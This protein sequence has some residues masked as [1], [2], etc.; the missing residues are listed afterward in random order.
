M[1]GKVY[2]IGAGPGD[3]ELLTRKAARI[4]AAAEVVLHDALVAQEILSLIAAGAEVRNVGKRCGRKSI[5]Q[6]ELHALLI[7]HARSGRAVVR[8]QGGDPLIFGRAGEEMAAL[9]DAGIEFDIV[10]GVTAASAAAAAAQIS[11]TNRGM[12]SKAIFLSGHRRPVGTPFDWEALPV[13]DATLVIY[14]PGDNYE[15]IMSNLRAAGWPGDTPCAVVSNASTGKQLILRTDL[16]ALAQASEAPAP[17]LLIVGEVTRSE[18]RE[19]A[20]AALPGTSRA[21]R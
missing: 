11:L 21:K 1:S 6:E 7:G 5:T 2:F 20:A 17:A 15:E 3:P 12:A 18:T 16:A 19:L 8:L 4:L 10:P 13:S 9:R 14:M